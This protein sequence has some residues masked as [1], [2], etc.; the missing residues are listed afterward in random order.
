MYFSDVFIILLNESGA[1]GFLAFQSC[2]R[3]L[4]NVAAL[5]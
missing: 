3:H 1:F 2:S 4:Y 5:Q